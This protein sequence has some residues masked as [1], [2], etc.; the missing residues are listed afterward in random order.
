MK[1]KNEDRGELAEYSAV[2]QCKINL[3]T[4]E[5]TTSSWSKVGRF[6]I[7]TRP[8]IS[9]KS[10]SSV[11]PAHV[12]DGKDSRSTVSTS[13][14]A[15]CTL[16][17]LLLEQMQHNFP[18][19]EGINTSTPCSVLPFTTVPETIVIGLSSSA[20]QHFIHV[21]RQQY[22][23]ELGF[24]P[25]ISAPWQQT[26]AAMKGNVSPS[27]DACL[28]QE[29]A[30]KEATCLKSPVS[31]TCFNT[32]SCITKKLL[33]DYWDQN[34]IYNAGENCYKEWLDILNLDSKPCFL[35]CA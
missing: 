7:E 29:L 10:C 8:C 22:P 9:V 18:D 19:D 15:G 12:V 34:R 26:L 31:C 3:K 5:I 33:W 16:M 14:L 35:L 17:Y 13:V 23:D 21:S 27:P 32:S 24:P 1:L 28:L 4:D 6:S 30:K 25:K 20:F 11:M 2:M